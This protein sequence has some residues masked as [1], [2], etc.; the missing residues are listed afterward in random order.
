MSTIY[1]R[2]S[3][4]GLSESACRDHYGT[5]LALGSRLIGSHLTDFASVAHLSPATIALYTTVFRPCLCIPEC[6]FHKLRINPRQ[7]RL[8]LVEASVTHGCAFC[9]A[10]T[11]NMGDVLNGPL[12]AQCARAGRI[13]GAREEDG[14]HE[15]LS[16]IREVCTFPG[17]L[18]AHTRKTFL[19]K[20][21][22][23]AYTQV[24]GMVAFMAWLNF[25][26]DVL[27]MP[28]EE[29]LAPFA[30]EFL[31]SR[32]LPFDVM[33]TVGGEGSDPVGQEKVRIVRSGE[34]AKPLRRIQAQLRNAAAFAG[35]T[36]HVSR[37]MSLETK[38]LKY[39]PKTLREIEQ[40]RQRQFGCTLLFDQ[41]MT[42]I[43]VKRALTFAVHEV[44]FRDEASEWTRV[45]KF[46]LVYVF[47]KGQVANP[48]LLR[49]AVALASGPLLTATPG[50][51]GEGKDGVAEIQENLEHVYAAAAST[52]T[53]MD[54][55]TAAARFIYSASG[56]GGSVK[57]AGTEEKLL[58]YVESPEA[59][60]DVMGL[61]GMCGLMH[62]MA[63][64][65]GGQ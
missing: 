50:D 15:L 43:E 28:L 5:F 36:P 65:C 12:F 11:A 20:Y 52:D 29:G 55:L 24:A 42:D 9:T 4:H 31:G 30:K 37:A 54:A 13:V 58:T 34:G 17:T 46:A 14:D 21:G 49:D 27:D 51:D 40:W 57:K 61:L 3:P 18:T 63:V 7:R 38:S 26:M 2:V 22:P 56:P 62:R 16:L 44:F 23:A 53:P 6:D 1:D 48:V 32:D 35:L 19:S 59:I 25:I 33:D 41:H 47:A 60:M 39:V 64:M 10:H 8:L 45:E